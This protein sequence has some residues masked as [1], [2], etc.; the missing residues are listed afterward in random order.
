MPFIIWY[1]DPAT[2]SVPTGYTNH[3]S[4]LATHE[5]MDMLNRL[6]TRFDAIIK[7]LELFKVRSRVKY[8]K[9]LLAACGETQRSAAWALSVP[10]LSAACSLRLLPLS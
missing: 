6:Y 5:V 8:R 1:R 7:E 10:S 3:C 9:L 2:A 4:R